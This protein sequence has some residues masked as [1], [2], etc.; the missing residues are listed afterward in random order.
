MGH[1]LFLAEFRG[2]QSAAGAGSAPAPVPV[3]TLPASGFG[4]SPAF[5]FA[6]SKRRSS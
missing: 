2:F 5:E 6:P 4:G 1:R 3:S